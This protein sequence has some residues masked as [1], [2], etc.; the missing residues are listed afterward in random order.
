MQRSSW[1]ILPLPMDIYTS[2]IECWAFHT[3][4]FRKR[5]KRTPCWSKYIYIAV[6]LS[7]PNISNVYY[8][9]TSIN[10]KHK[11]PFLWICRNSNVADWFSCYQALTSI[12]FHGGFM[13]CLRDF[14]FTI[15]KKETVTLIEL[16]SASVGG[17]FFLRYDLLLWRYLWSVESG[18]YW[19]RIKETFF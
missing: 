1:V 13:L 5:F 8:S 7:F 11:F 6:P 19:K 15:T 10:I 3:W 18:M 2:S 16:I 14:K 9:T 17:G 12:Y 4:P